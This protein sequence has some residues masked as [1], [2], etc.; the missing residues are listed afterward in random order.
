SAAG[1]S[2]ST[3]EDTPLVVPAPGVLGNDTDVDGDAM[4]AILVAG[5][6][7]GTL[8]LSSDGSFTYTPSP[9]FNG[10]DSFTYKVSDGTLES[11]PATVA[12]TVSPVDDAPQAVDDHY[13][14][15]ED[16]TLAIAAPGLLANDLDVDSSTLTV[17]L[18]GAPAHGTLTLNPDGSFT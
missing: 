15:N 5:P 2:Y 18:V 16:G 6:S 1:D 14:M 4:S 7:H 12:I 13:G 17:L 9:N 8:T 3:N 10:S 11:D